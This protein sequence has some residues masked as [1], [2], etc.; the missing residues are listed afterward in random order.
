VELL[1]RYGGVDTLAVTKEGGRSV[2]LQDRT[3]KGECRGGGDGT[4]KR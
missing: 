4:R 2:L 1:E 3:R